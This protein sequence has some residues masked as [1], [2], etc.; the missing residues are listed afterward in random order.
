MTNQRPMRVP[1]WLIGGVVLAALTGGG[2]YWWSTRR[3]QDPDRPGPDLVERVVRQGPAWFRDVTAGSGLH[4][5]CR[6]GEEADH[7]TILETLGGGVALLDHDGDGLLD[8]FV[9]G[10]GYFDGPDKKQIKGHPCKLFKNLGNFQF[11]DITAEVGLDQTAWWYTQGAAVADHDRDGWPDL[12]VTGYGRMA[13]F[14][15]E[16]DGK[17]GRR[18]VE[19]T[20]KVG[21]HEKAPIHWSTSAGWADLHGDG[22]P[23]LYV[24]HYVDWSFDNN[25]LCKGH[26]LG[27][28]QDICGPERFKPLIHALYRNER[29]N[30]AADEKER[31]FRNVSAEHRFKAEGCGLGVVL[32]DLNGDGKPDVY[33]GNDTNPNLLFLN[34]GGKLEEVGV[35]AGVANDEIGKPDGSMGVDA[36]DFDGSGRPSLW[37][38]NFQS[39]YHAL[40]LNLGKE[41][42][43]HYSRGSGAAA[44][45]ASWIGF[46]TS[47]FD[48][49]NDGWEDLVIANGHVFRHPGT[50]D[51]KQRPILLHN[52]DHKGQRFFKDM[53]IQAGDF[54]QAPLLGRGLAIGDLDN[55]GWPDIVVSHTNSPIA[56]LRNEAAAARK[57]SNRWLG[58]K[59]V[60]AK[61]RDV[62]GSTVI[63][64]NGSQKLTRFAKGGGSYL[65]SSD[66][67]I[68]FGLGDS[69]PARR[70]TVRWSWG[71]EQQ[72]DLAPNAYW[73]LREG[74]LA[75]EKAP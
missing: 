63:L 41:R 21:L 64:E 12:L 2:A 72:W 25:P 65:S 38:T 40:Y 11:K 61:N 8:L 67:R 32:A 58:V 54:F 9:I 47:F 68:L 29:R 22:W 44:I 16:A 69:N 70:V 71:K 1:F 24:C 66:R 35:R 73:I 3:N 28:K 20:E 60:G 52:V 15:N 39:Q 42:F 46:G 26:A 43:H 36:G 14:H 48:A 19:V 75:A 34:R 74:E 23:D 55:D 6:N 10:G 51:R 7:Y 53:S 37:V 59:L 27:I 18:F 31:S 57:P 30:G 49:D 5:T 45:G 62:V 50:G 4:F 13:L 33:V 56:L 17:G